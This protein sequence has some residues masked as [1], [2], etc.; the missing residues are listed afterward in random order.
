MNTGAHLHR[1]HCNV[2][3]ALQQSIIDLLGEQ[4]LAADVC[5]RLVQDL[6]TRGLDDADL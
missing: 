3:A 6:V 4:S 5:Q 1:V 2:D